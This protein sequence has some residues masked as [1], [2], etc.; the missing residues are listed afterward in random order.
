MTK[1]LLRLEREG[2]RIE[3][4][5]NVCMIER[6]HCFFLYSQKLEQGQLYLTAAWRLFSNFSNFNQDDHI[7]LSSS[8]PRFLFD[9]ETW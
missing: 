9:S 7:T 5:F 6:T 1:I 2:M 8:V 3:F 4:I